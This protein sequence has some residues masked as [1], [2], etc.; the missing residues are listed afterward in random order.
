MGGI[1]FCR[2]PRFGI[3]CVVSLSVR[4]RALSL[5]GPEQALIRKK[6][7]YILRLKAWANEADLA[8]RAARKFPRVLLWLPEVLSLMNPQRQHKGTAIAAAK[9]TRKRPL[10]EFIQAL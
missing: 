5:V 10:L 7:E 2:F 6:F 8:Y 9:R 3:N 4:E 1:K